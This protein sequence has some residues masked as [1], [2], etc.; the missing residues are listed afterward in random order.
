MIT[1]CQ[2]SELMY[3]LFAIICNVCS[4]ESSITP[5]VCRI[6][7]KVEMSLHYIVGP[8]FFTHIRSVLSSE[9]H[10]LCHIARLGIKH[11]GPS[12]HWTDIHYKVIS[13]NIVEFY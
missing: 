11:P 10:E 13:C 5:Y 2:F 7:L 6:E 9:D 3:Y 4:K 8:F 1:Q 12:I